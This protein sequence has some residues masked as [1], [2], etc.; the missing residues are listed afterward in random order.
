MAFKS[1]RDIVCAVDAAGCAKATIDTPRLLLLGFL[2][3][4]YIAFGGLLA[5]IVGGGAPGLAAANPGLQKFVF[6]AVFPVGLM[7]VVIAGAELFTGNTATCLPAVL[8]RR[9]SWGSVAR[10][11]VLSYLGNFAGSLFVAYFLTFLTSLLLKDPWLSSIIGI[12]EAKTSQAFLPLLLKAVGCNWLVCLAVWLAVSADDVAGKIAAIWF[13]IMA[14]VAIGFE[15]SVANM[16]FIPA[17]MFYGADV[18]WA[19]F[20]VGNLVPVTL[21]NIIG[22]MVFVGVVYWLLYGARPGTGD[23]AA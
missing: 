22:G 15:H 11:W 3:G 21:G 2:A 12:A 4:A 8:A 10:N 5:V 18:T 23:G 17:G 7:L 20:L 6:G 1:P 13:P 14:F 19:D 16:Y 9:I